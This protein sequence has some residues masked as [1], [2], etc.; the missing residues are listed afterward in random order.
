LLKS[1]K[2]YWL[3]AVVTP[4]LVAMELLSQARLPC[5]FQCLDASESSSFFDAP[6]RDDCKIDGDFYVLNSDVLE[7]TL[8]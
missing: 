5:K 1:E 2:V 6:G 7:E 8:H 3:I 4:Q